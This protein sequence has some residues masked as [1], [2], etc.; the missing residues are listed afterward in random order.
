MTAAVMA[1]DREACVAAGM[2]D[3]VAKPIQPGDLL[4]TLVKW[5]HSKASQK[6]SVPGVRQLPKRCGCQRALPGFNLGGVMELLGGNRALFRK[7]LKQFHE[8][9]ATAD[10]DLDTL[11]A[12]GDFPGA[13]SLVHGI[14]GVAG[15]IG[16]TELHQA[17][18]ALEPELNDG[19]A[20]ADKAAFERA[21][22][23]VLDSAS[24]LA[25]QGT[26]ISIVPEFECDKCDW[27][28]AAS[29]FKQLRVLVESDEFVPH[30]LIAEL[31]GCGKLS[32]NAPKAG[33]PGALRGQ[34]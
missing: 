1:H 29:L 2:N 5:V 9:F 11:I 7:L 17:A 12:S 15:N 10:A 14:K 27:Q 25:K 13:A 4:Q 31:K 33:E 16:A 26:S 21:L 19:R 22:A 24:R 30:E 32:A 28:L 8:H 18:A 20:P 6:L 23:Q 34:Y 3:H